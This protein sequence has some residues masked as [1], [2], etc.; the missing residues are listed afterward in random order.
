MINDYAT[1]QDAIARWLARTD[2]ALSIPDF[3]ML[4][5]ARINSDLRTRS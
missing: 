1:L 4:A 2:L 5:E 3:I